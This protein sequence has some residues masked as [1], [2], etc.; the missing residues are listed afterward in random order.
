MR[1]SIKFCLVFFYF[2][3]CISDGTKT[4]VQKPLII[5]EVEGCTFSCDVNKTEVIWSGFKTTDK[6]KVTGQFKTFKSKKLHTQ[7]NFLSVQDL[8]EGLDFVIAA[9]SLSSNDPIRDLNLK[10][11]FF[12]FFVNH[13]TIKGSFGKIENDSIVVEIELIEQKK[14]FKLGF[15]YDHD[16]VE[17]KGTVNLL[18]QLNA[19]KA[20]DSIERKCKDLHK[21]EDGVSKTWEEVEIHIKAP[22]IKNCN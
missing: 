16:V 10:E 20:F 6:I 21:G 15:S 1:Y 8:V 3:A 7:K 5:S 22:I 13:L 2:S 19:Q 17:I 9:G 11:H 12:K 4:K 18:K 14:S